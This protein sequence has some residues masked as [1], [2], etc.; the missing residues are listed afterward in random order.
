MRRPPGPQMVVAAPILGLLRRARASDVAPADVAFV[1]DA[2][3]D[4]DSYT[5]QV[6]YA[7]GGPWSRHDASVG[8]VLTYTLAL[9]T[10]TY[11]S[12]VVP[13]TGATPGTA[14]AEQTVTV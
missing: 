14:S 8:N 7:S 2:V 1:W 12:R 6:G 11:Y 3:V 13:Y 5:L 4:A 10:G 9:T